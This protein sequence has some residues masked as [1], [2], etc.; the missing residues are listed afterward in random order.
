M[1]NIQATMEKATTGGGKA[2]GDSGELIFCCN[3]YRYL[4]RPAAVFA[5]S[6]HG[7][8]ATRDDGDVVFRCNQCRFLLQP[9]GFFA[10][11]IQ[12]GVD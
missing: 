1:E 5:T 11:S 9:A 3:R 7:G 10:T 4:L 2:S 12:N 6:I 8:A